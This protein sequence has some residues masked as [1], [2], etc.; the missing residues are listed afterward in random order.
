VQHFLQDA[1]QMAAAGKLGQ[2]HR[3]LV[4]THARH[5]VGRAHAG[6]YAP[7]GLYQ[8]QVAAVMAECVVD[9]LEMVQ[10][11][12]QDGQLRVVAFAFLDLLLQPVAQHAAV[13]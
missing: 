12:E 6:L 9:F 1:F 13:G 3:E 10:V 11:D 7:P 4:A 5:R 2:Y 8:Q